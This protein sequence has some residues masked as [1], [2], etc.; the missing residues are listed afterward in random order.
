MNDLSTPIVMPLSCR[1]GRHRPHPMARW[2][3]GYYFTR[4]ERCGHDLVRTAFEGWDVPKGYKVVWQQHP[5]EGR[6]DVALV[7]EEQEAATPEAAASDEDAAESQIELPIQQVLREL[8]DEPQPG[9]ELEQP[10]PELEPA[11]AAEA[12]PYTDDEPDAE[13]AVPPPAEEAAADDG[14]APASEDEAETELQD[15]IAAAP[16][17]IPDFMEDESETLYWD[18][19][20]GSYVRTP[21]AV[22]LANGRPAPREAV[23]GVEPPPSPPP[24]FPI[25]GR[26]RIAPEEAAVPP[27][28]NAPLPNRLVAMSLGASLLALIAVMVLVMIEIGRSSA[29]P[30][31][32]TETVL[33]DQTGAEPASSLVLPEGATSGFVSASLLNC[34]TAPAEQSRPVRTLS[35]GDEVQILAL[36]P[37]WLSI[38][39]RGRQCWASSRYITANQ[40]L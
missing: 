38:S 33:A 27:E 18:P 16:G 24:F 12:A 15:Q 7:P 14:E 17:A 34:R 25:R 31:T 11:M 29:L 6:E 10:G 28:P 22:I 20:T 32:D 19:V 23:A 9:S 37:G 3:D 39:H 5:P 26:D 13:V 2:N 8:G 35:R 40:P 1:L 4:C 36:E 30:A 21:P